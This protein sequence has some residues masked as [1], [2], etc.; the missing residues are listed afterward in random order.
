MQY[1][2]NHSADYCH[3]VFQF[4]TYR[5]TTPKENTQKDRILIVIILIRPVRISEESWKEAVVTKFKHNGGIRLEVLNTPTKK[6][7]D[8][9]RGPRSDFEHSTSPTRGRQLTVMSA[10][11]PVG[12][13]TQYLPNGRQRPYSYD[14]PLFQRDPSQG[15]LTLKFT[16]EKKCIKIISR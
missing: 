1:R 6:T 14:S 7:E 9:I 8:I 12:I 5:L 13:Q 11:C 2:H 15:T 4:V 3:V 10:R 16:Q